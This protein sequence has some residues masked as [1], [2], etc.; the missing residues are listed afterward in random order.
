MEPFTRKIEELLA[1]LLD[2]L[3]EDLNLVKVERKDLLDSK[4]CL[5]IPLPISVHLS[6]FFRHLQTL[7]VTCTILKSVRRVEET[8]NP[9]RIQMKKMNAWPRLRL[10]QSEILDARRHTSYHSLSHCQLEREKGEEYVAALC[11]A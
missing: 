3:H 2:G 1:Y 6:C 11:A 9:K 7:K 8:W 10:M 5:D 4:L